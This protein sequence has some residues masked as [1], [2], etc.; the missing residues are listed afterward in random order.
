M[1]YRRNIPLPTTAIRVSMTSSTVAGACRIKILP[2]QWFSLPGFA[3][4]ASIS[5]STFF[6]MRVWQ[7]ARILLAASF[8]RV[9][10]SFHWLRV[11]AID[12]PLLSKPSSK[13]ASPWPSSI[14]SWT[15][16]SSC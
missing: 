8:S 15:T 2:L 5:P 7:S 13:T 1:R 16:P 11:S 14:L 4:D 12:S 3:L 6:V 9:Y 10:A